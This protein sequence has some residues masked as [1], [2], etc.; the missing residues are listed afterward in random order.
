[1]K[2][3]KLLAGLLAVGMTLSF[4]GCNN[5]KK[6]SDEG[7][8]VLKVYMIGSEKPDTKLVIEEVNKQLKEK[9]GATIEWNLISGGAFQ[10][11]INMMYAANETFD[12]C[13]TGYANKLAPAVEN[14]S[15]MGLND[16][17]KENVPELKD[18]LPEYLW[19]VATVDGEIYAVPN[20]QIN[21]S[22]QALM[23]FESD[24]EKYGIDMEKVKIPADLEQFF[25]KIKAVEPDKWVYRATGSAMVLSTLDVD[26]YEEL[27]T[28]LKFN[29]ETNKVENTYKTEAFIDGMKRTRDWY[30]KGYIRSDIASVMDDN[31]DYY[32]KKYVF[33]QSNWRPASEGGD[34][35]FRVNFPGEK[36]IYKIIAQPEITTD[37]SDSTM[38]SISRTS[39]NPVKAIKYIDLINTDIELYNLLSHGIEGKHW[40]WTDENKTHLRPIASDLYQPNIAWAYGNQFNSY[41]V[42]GNSADIWEKEKEFNASA[43]VSPLLGFR[44]KTDSIMTEIAQVEAVIAE[45][46][47]LENGS[48]DWNEHYPKFLRRLEEAGIQTIIDEYQKQVDEFLKNK[49]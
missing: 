28:G 44:A 7:N 43:K 1:M 2:G 34:A 3:K 14:G 20:Q 49:K 21:A 41:V 13:F 32:A 4:T 9:I 33:T 11:K 12:I 16:L 17:I 40:E 42:E 10:E 26:K 36:P 47:M 23:V 37:L 19:D 24:A 48:G 18:K 27:R 30:Q 25:E 39:K 8:D 45:F 38:L 5:A 15:L 35:K 31:E 22:V 46:K 6:T 29:F